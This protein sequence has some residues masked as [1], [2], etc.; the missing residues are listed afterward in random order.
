M[1]IKHTG[2][3]LPKMQFGSLLRGNTKFE[4]VVNK[5]SLALVSSFSDFG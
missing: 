3:P 4:Q 1:C 2:N 5:M